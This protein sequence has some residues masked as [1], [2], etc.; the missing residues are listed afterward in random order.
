MFIPIGLGVKDDGTLGGKMSFSGKDEVLLS[1]V[2]GGC[3]MVIPYH[4]DSDL[5]SIGNVR[6]WCGMESAAMPGLFF[7]CSRCMNKRV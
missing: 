1:P 5:E 7:M 4:K 6:I 3:G 2:G